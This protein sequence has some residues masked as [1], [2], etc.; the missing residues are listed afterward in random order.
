VADNG[1]PYLQMDFTNGALAKTGVWTV[2]APGGNPNNGPFLE[3]NTRV[4][5]HTNAGQY[6]DPDTGVLTGV[7]MKTTFMYVDFYNLDKPDNNADDSHVQVATD[8]LDTT[9]GRY[10]EMQL[11]NSNSGCQNFSYEL[12]SKMEF[13]KTGTTTPFTIGAFQVTMQRLALGERI[14]IAAGGIAQSNQNPSSY[15]LAASTQIAGP[16]VETMTYGNV[17][18]TEWLM[19]EGVVKDVPQI[20]VEDLSVQAEWR[21]TDTWYMYYQSQVGNPDSDNDIEQGIW[22]FFLFISNPVCVPI[23]T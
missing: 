21:D 14:G 12:V 13:F 1:K 19:F 9:V 2:L 23:N 5:Y 16:T 4:F 11:C 6:P 8:Q 18:N 22:D 10:Q 20:P 15:V 7:D 3:L 17:S